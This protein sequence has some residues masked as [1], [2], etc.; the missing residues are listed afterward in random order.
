MDT[1]MRRVPFTEQ[2]ATLIADLELA[3]GT[4]IESARKVDVVNRVLENGTLG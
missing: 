2:L 1:I 3:E 4:F